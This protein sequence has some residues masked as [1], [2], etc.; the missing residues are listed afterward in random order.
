MFLRAVVMAI[1]V[2]VVLTLHLRPIDLL[3]VYFNCARPGHDTAR[4]LHK[5]VMTNRCWIEVGAICLG[6]F[7]VHT[8]LWRAI[9]RHDINVARQLFNQ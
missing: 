1:A 4:W 6:V 8:V 3:F 5:I 9:G 7:V 2:Q